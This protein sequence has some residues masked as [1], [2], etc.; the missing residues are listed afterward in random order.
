MASSCSPTRQSAISPIRGIPMRRT[1]SS[2]SRSRTTA[3]G[4]A[5]GWS[6]CARWMG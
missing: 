6:A 1:H 4:T 5:P 3:N 2:R